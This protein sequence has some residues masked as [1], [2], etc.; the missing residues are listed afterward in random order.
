[1]VEKMLIMQVNKFWDI[2]EHGQ[3]TIT[4]VRK[5]NNLSKVKEYKNDSPR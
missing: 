2:L 1:M 5:S 3:Q 4:N